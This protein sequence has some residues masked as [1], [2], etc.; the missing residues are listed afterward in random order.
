VVQSREIKPFQPP[1]EARM[2]ER[3]AAMKS[4]LKKVIVVLAV[5]GLIPAGF[6]TWLIHRGGLTHA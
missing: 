2:A 1:A 6:A 3:G 4:Q 5:W